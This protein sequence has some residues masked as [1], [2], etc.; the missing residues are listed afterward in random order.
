MDNIF[1]IAS[2]SVYLLYL[3]GSIGHRSVVYSTLIV[4]LI[5]QEK[6]PWNINYSVVPIV[7]Y[8]AVGVMLRVMD[9]NKTK[10]QYNWE[11]LGKSSFLTLIG[12]Y[13]FMKG[14]NEFDD[15]LRFNHGMW[16]MLAGIAS[17]YGFQSTKVTSIEAK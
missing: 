14:L 13:F 7:F 16:H 11:M 10:V 17:W 6:D 4:S 15:Y 9:M 1:V 2:F 12:V 5:A 8:G 3:S